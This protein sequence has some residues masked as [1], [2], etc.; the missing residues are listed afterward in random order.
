MLG[1]PDLGPV[2][3][4]RDARI[5]QGFD[6]LWVVF[7]SFAL[8]IL[9]GLGCGRFYATSV[10]LPFLYRTPKGFECLDSPP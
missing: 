2:E 1:F 3:V 10:A 4:D 5:L 7:P 6:F 8:K 9:D